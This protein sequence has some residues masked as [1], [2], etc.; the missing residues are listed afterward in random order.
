[1]KYRYYFKDK[2]NCLFSKSRHFEL[3]FVVRHKIYQWSKENDGIK[4]LIHWWVKN[5][6]DADFK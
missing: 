4:K 5:R 1:M 2:I 3:S 6:I